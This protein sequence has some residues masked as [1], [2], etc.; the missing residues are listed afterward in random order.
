M[1]E[2]SANRSTFCFP[3]ADERDPDPALRAWMTKNI[4]EAIRRDGL[5][6]W[7]LWPE[8]SVTS[9]VGPDLATHHRTAPPK[10]H[11]DEHA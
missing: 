6:R 7:I 10:H 3:H 11:G 5:K 4:R 1:A 8:G 9:F 2:V